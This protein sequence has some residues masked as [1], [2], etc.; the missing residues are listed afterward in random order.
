MHTEL[1]TRSAGRLYV[2]LRWCV[3]VEAKLCAVV[4]LTTDLFSW[5]AVPCLA[6]HGMVLRVDP[7][8]D[9][10]Y[11]VRDAFT[12]HRFLEMLPC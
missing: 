6:V 11:G 10:T 12:H 3:A 9:G 4:R 5:A 2:R 8:P 1:D 7:Q